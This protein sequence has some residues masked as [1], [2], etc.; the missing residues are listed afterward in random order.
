MVN[1]T[2][3]SHPVNLYAIVV[4]TMTYFMNTLHIERFKVPDTFPSCVVQEKSTPSFPSKRLNRAHHAASFATAVLCDAPNR[5]YILYSLSVILR[6][7]V[8]AGKDQEWCTSG[9]SDRAN[10]ILTV[11]QRLHKC[12]QCDN[13]AFQDGL[14]TPTK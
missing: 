13:A 5:Q 1:C 8:A 7:V 6:C 4:Q 14:A 2:F 10:F 11:C 12:N 3:I 9:V